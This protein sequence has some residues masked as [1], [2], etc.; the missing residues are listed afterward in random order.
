MNLL[1]CKYFRYFFVIFS[2]G[3]IAQIIYFASLPI[4]SR[5]YSVE[6]FSNLSVFTSLL[7]LLST[8]ACLR[9]DVAISLAEKKSDVLRLF[10]LSIILSTCFSILILCVVLVLWFF[11]VIDVYLIFLPLAIWLCSISNLVINFY[12][13]Y[14]QYKKVS[15]LKVLQVSSMSFSQI[16]L[17]VFLPTIGSIGLIL[18][19][20]LNYTIGSLFQLKNIIVIRRMNKISFYSLK[21]VA[22]KYS[23]YLKYST[24]DSIFNL[25]GLHLPII[26]LTFMYD[27][28]IMG[29]FYMG[30]RLIQTPVGILITSVSQ[31]Y[32]SNIQ[33]NLNGNIFNFSMKVVLCLAAFGFLG[34]LIFY[35]IRE[36]LIILI[37]GNEWAKLADLSIWL[38]PWFFLQ[39]VS[40]PISTVMYALKKHKQMMVLT[41][42]GLV[43]RVFPIIFLIKVHSG[44][45]LELFSLANAVY[46][47][48]CLVCF[49]YF[50]KINS[51]KV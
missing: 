44:F 8:I 26:L 16:T 40:S 14:K 12:L 24:F 5:L 31:I 47:L 23:H 46:Y 30:M 13:K 43:I 17:G 25:L 49:L 2:G 21:L 35:F 11:E 34:F 32:Y 18:G 15:S 37:L 3:V 27:N 36:S 6:E 19:Q 22:I 9:Y 51:G 41:W 42:F 33:D 45:V 50:A 10:L 39:L 7:I 29:I 38:I 1:Q 20:V 48:V 28:Y 4:I